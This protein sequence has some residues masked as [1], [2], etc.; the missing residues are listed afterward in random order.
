MRI[1]HRGR[2]GG[3]RYGAAGTLGIAAVAVA[4][5]APP[6]AAAATPAAPPGP[7]TASGDL[8]GLSAA[9]I[10]DRAR[11][12]AGS[13]QSVRLTMRSPGMTLHLALDEKG[14]C[15]GKAALGSGKKNGGSGAQG[16]VTFV[17]HGRTVWLKPDSAF[18]KS[19]IGGERGASVAD[20]VDG[21]YIKGT[22]ADGLM[23]GMA[24]TCDLK[25]LRRSMTDASG[26]EPGA[27]GDPG[28]RKPG[29]WQRGET[30]EVHGTPAVEVSRSVPEGR[31][32]VLV[33]DEGKPY[34]LKLTRSAE[35]GQDELELDDFNRPVSAGT[36]PA[37][38]TIGVTE[39]EQALKAPPA[40]SV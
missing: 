6:T 27:Q 31:V 23:N 40:E 4:M 12:Q 10:A 28:S 38:Q 37:A 7:S 29:E 19:Q 26:S 22:T 11:A 21:R 36:P 1:Q 30:Q 25:T 17:K 15:A 13:M 14:T 39:L 18:W 34:P 2:G 33:A 20:F 24:A 35:A 32:S 3:R 16:T 9:E 5:T 8:D